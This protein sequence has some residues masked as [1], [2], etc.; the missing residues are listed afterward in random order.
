MDKRGQVYVLAAIIMSIIIFGMVSVSNKALQENIAS[1]FERIANNY[2]TETAKLVNSV[3]GEEEDIL[4]A[5]RNFTLL[6]ASYAKAQSPRFELISIFDYNN[7]LYIGNFLKERI[8]VRCND[9]ICDDK[10]PIEG[11]Y[12]NV[13]ATLSFD[14]LQI[15]V[16]VYYNAVG[17]CESQI[18][19]DPGLP[20]EEIIIS[21]GDLAY[22]FDL[23]KDQPEVVIVGWETN[24]R[25]RKVFTKG[26]FITST[27]DATT[28]AD[29]CAEPGSCTEAPKYSYCKIGPA[30][31]CIPKCPLI[32]NEDECE[33]NSPICLWDTYG[34]VC[35]E[36]T[37]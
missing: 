13:P 28:L 32:N 15:D 34:M 10:P 29:Y 6:F 19:Y 37:A 20:I 17:N 4:P 5:F 16:P 2:A 9:G 27:G 18:P 31:E 11:C 1:D 7:N 23:R 21:I 30:A 24:A 25:Q 3:A 12:G 14:G 33:A 8:I 35:T 26:S 36:P 22:K